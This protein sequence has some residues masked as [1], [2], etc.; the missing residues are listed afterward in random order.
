MATLKLTGI[1]RINISLIE[2]KRVRFLLQFGGNKQQSDVEIE[3]DSG[4]AMAL[5][6]G[7]EKFQ[8]THQIPIPPTLRPQ[9]PPLLS[10]VESGE[11]NE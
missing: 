6:R 2:G 9:G 1:N 5:M 10:V 7:L 8:A 3:M 11:G 4:D